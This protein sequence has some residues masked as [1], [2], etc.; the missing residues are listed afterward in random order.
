V[1]SSLSWPVLAGDLLEKMNTMVH[2][3][4]VHGTL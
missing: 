1:R 4:P 3:E 2:G